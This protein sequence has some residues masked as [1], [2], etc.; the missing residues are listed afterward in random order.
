[1]SQTWDKEKSDSLAE[2]KPINH[3]IQANSFMNHVDSDLIDFRS[4][5]CQC[6]EKTDKWLLH[7]FGHFSK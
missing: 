5:A 2:K 6:N 1:M 7:V 3:E 4:L